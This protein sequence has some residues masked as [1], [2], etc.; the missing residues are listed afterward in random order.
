MMRYICAVGMLACELKLLPP[1]KV[2][3]EPPSLE[4]MKLLGSFGLIHR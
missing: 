3:A 1:L 4:I 2:T